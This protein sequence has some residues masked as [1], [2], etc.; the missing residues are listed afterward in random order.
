MSPR[1]STLFRHLRPLC[2]VGLVAGAACS[3][4]LPIDNVVDNPGV[5][6]PVGVIQG[7]VSYVGPPPCFKNG[8]VQGVMVILLFA[9]NNPPPPDGLATTALNFTAIAGDKMFADLARPGPAEPGGGDKAFCPSLDSGPVAA[10]SDYTISELD[11]GQY[12]LR[13]FYSRQNAFNPLFDYANLPVVGDSTGGAVFDPSATTPKF[14]PVTIGQPDKTGKLVMPD[15]GYL[16]KGVP[17][18]V[19][20]A[21]R[22]NRPYFYV[23]YAGSRGFANPKGTAK[24]VQSAWPYDD[25]VAGD[26]QGIVFPQDHPITSNQKLECLGKVD[27]TCSALEFAEKSLPS[28]HFRYGLPGLVTDTTATDAWLGK[29]AKP[30]I[31]FGDNKPLPF[32][33]LNPV[34]S[35]V[36]SGNHF[37]LTRNFFSDGTPAVLV[38]NEALES[39]G[40]IADLFPAVVLAKMQN[41]DQGNLL[42]PLAPQSDPIVVVQG[43]TLTGN[44]M[45]ASSE[46]ELVGGGLATCADATSCGDPGGKSPLHTKGGVVLAD[47]FTALIR[48]AALCVRPSLSPNLTGKLVVPYQFDPNPANGGDKS[49]VNEKRLKDTQPRV[50]NVLYGCLPP[51]YYSINVVQPTGQA[52]SL[53]NMLG[54]CSYTATG[55]PNEECKRYPDNVAASLMTKGFPTRPLLSS[56]M[57]YKTNPDGSI[58]TDAGGAKIPLIVHIT[59]SARCMH[60]SAGDAKVLVSNAVHED[61]N[62]NGILDGGEDKNGNG[63]LDMA[64]PE[65]CRELKPVGSKCVDD[66][67]CGAATCKSGICSLK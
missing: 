7:T 32:Y 62:H 29:N 23:D 44:S 22:T 25:T 67:Q 45:K 49:L 59:P 48:P 13:A 26:V 41:D 50:E 57:I 27:P 18:I 9:Y 30:D 42:E 4:N 65:I 47:D 6:K 2:L 16:T 36:D 3:V 10:T 56:Q 38:D 55:I 20:G 61:E 35:D 21:L 19:G 8:R 40:K 1:T 28:I 46:S 60:P 53:P 17:V 14:I 12:Q 33:D 54:T 52:W 11:A 15:T 64:I 51:G 39:L 43:F 37:A 24:D 34:G 58:A 5:N 31:A 66:I 63:I